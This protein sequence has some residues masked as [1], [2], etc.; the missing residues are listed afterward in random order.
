MTQL[1]ENKRPGLFLINYFSPFLP[2]HKPANHSTM[3]RTTN[4]YASPPIATHAVLVPLSRTAVK[5][6]AAERAGKTE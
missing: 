6:K 2:I 4:K 5:W 3:P 1:I